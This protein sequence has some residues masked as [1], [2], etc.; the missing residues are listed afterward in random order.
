MIRA[1]SRMFVIADRNPSY[2]TQNALS[3]FE[4]D[5]QVLG[6]AAVAVSQAPYARALAF[7]KVEAPVVRGFRANFDKPR[8]A[9]L[10]FRLRKRLRQALQYD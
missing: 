4:D 5:R 6:F 2:R 1:D 7:L 8:H 9:R 3:L 10:M